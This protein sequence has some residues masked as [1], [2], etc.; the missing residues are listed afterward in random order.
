MK[1]WSIAWVW[2]LA[3]T[4]ALGCSDDSGGGDGGDGVSGTRFPALAVDPDR[5][6]FPGATLGTTQLREVTFTNVG[7]GLLNI[8]EI[9]PSDALGPVEFKLI[10]PPVPF[11]LAEAESA[12]LRVEYTVAD[13]GLDSGATL[14]GLTAQV[15][16]PGV[17]AHV[18]CEQRVVE[19]CLR[20]RRVLG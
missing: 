1:R 5:I 19:I 9:T 6:V 8:E 17:A 18:H 14:Q 16:L 2:L 20:H 13:E 11:Q 12:T 15:A 10:H 7:G 4:V 3:A